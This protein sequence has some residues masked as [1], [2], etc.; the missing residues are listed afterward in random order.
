MNPLPLVRTKLRLAG[1]VGLAVS[2]WIGLDLTTVSLT[3][4][5]S[6]YQP[7]LALTP[8][9]RGTVMAVDD[10]ERGGW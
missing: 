2:M 5:P 8:G 1:A 7:V 3:A 9:P 6:S 10:A 4:S